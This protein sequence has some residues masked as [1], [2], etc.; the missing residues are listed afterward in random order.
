MQAATRSDSR[1][2]ITGSAYHFPGDAKSH[3]SYWALLDSG[4]SVI[5]D[6]PSERF[7]IEPYYNADANVPG[8]TYAR[9]GGYVDG[10]FDFDHSFFRISRSEALEM[11][12]QQRW[13]LELCWQALENAGIRPSEV[14]G[15]S[16]GVFLGSGEVDYG[17]RTLWSGD[18]NRITTYARLGA[19]RATL[20]GRIGY[21]LGVH[22]PA[23]FVDTACSSS[24]AAVHLAAQSLLAG[25]C[26]IAIAGGITLMI[27]PQE[28][29]AGARVQAMSHLETCRPFDAKADGYM[30]GEGGGVVVMK[31]IDDAIRDGDRIDAVMAGS[32]MNNAGPRNGL[33]APNGIAQES[34]IRVALQR[35]N[36]KPESVAYVEA[37]GTGTLLGDPIELGALHNVYSKDVHRTYPLFVGSV[38]AQIGHLEAGAGMAGL[39]KAMLVL[40]KRRIP[41]Q[42]NFLEPNPRFRWD[43]SEIR[44]PR[45][46][47]AISDEA[48]MVGVSGFGISGTNVHMVLARATVTDPVADSVADS[49]AGADGP[50]HI[51]TLSAR[52]S[53]G[54]VQLAKE[55]RNVLSEAAIGLRDI[56]YTASARRDHWNHRVALVG[57]TRERLIEALDDFLTGNPTGTWHTADAAKSRP[58]VFLFPGQGAWK[59]GVGAQ[60]YND[61]AIFHRFVDECLAYLDPTLAADVMS[62]I[63]GE[64]PETVR[65]RQGQLAH[66]VVL[67]SLARTWME[68]GHEPEVVIG[69][70]L[71]EHVAAAVA[72]VMS[73]ED[74]L[75]AVE[76]RGRLFD[77]ETPPG[78][79]LAVAAG[80]DELKSRFDFGEALFIAGINGP[81]QTVVSGTAEAVNKVFATMT[82]MG[83]RVSLLNTYDTP[84]HSPMLAPMRASFG[85]ALATLRLQPPSI[86]LISTLTGKAAG[87]D[88]AT[89]EHWLDLVENP[90]LF[91]DALSQVKDQEY[92]FLEVGPGAALS[93]LA[94]AV[95]QKWDLAISSLSD[96]PDDESTESAGFAHACARLYC[97][98]SMRNWAPL[99]PQPPQPAALPTYPFERVHLEL[100]FL[101][102]AVVP[103]GHSDAGAI[104]RPALQT[105]RGTEMDAPASVELVQAASPAR[106][107]T[108]EPA[109]LDAI[110]ELARS[111][112][113]DT[114]T[115]DDDAPLVV[116]GFDSLA[117]TEL[118]VRLQQTFGRALPVALLARGV[119]LS[120][121]AAFFGN[122][123]SGAATGSTATTQAA[124]KAEFDAV[125]RQRQNLSVAGIGAPRES[126]GTPFAE[127]SPVVVLREGHGETIVLVH[128]VGGDVLCYQDL[129]TAWPG[130]PTVI[131]V[132]HPDADLPVLPAHRPLAELARF[133]RHEVERLL[134]RLPDRLG[135]WSFGGLVAL[136]MAAQWERAGQAA[137]PLMV[138]DSPLPTGDFAL[139]L[140][141]VVGTPADAPS[142][143]DV[144]ALYRDARF[145]E[146]RDLGLDQMRARL[147]PLEFARIARLYASNVLSI[148]LR[149]FTKVGAPIH[150]ALAACGSNGR[151][152]DDV[153]PHLQ[154]LTTG[155]VNVSVF[156][157]DH[158]SIVKG[159]SA[160]RLAAFLSRSIV[161][162]RIAVNGR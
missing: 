17:L 4:R 36:A 70:S 40:Q 136:E 134:G 20:A 109:V 100:P 73:V 53:A 143:A 35:A 9:G 133:Y 126:E 159:P 75:R 93:N 63:R 11:D 52:S 91:A 38:K 142:L 128:P 7:D 14:Y 99:Y 154:R 152:R 47:E 23:V 88:M 110:R 28:T 132:R 106:K 84:G 129:A 16:V 41:A 37:H 78:A 74:S 146:E 92:V 56:C 83:K 122:A 130:D 64:R 120:G 72:G 139:R 51:L 33:T 119:S 59:P 54:R 46:S 147:A 96:G 98:G 155:T 68:L 67:Y 13:M 8:T 161:D 39:I 105:A 79:M 90:V 131:G 127:E 102:G 118:R 140:K 22:G 145:I 19:S 113:S 82:G 85:D 162:E 95:T 43:T 26:D 30:R 45:A 148:S 112:A 61:N 121:L 10:V 160:Q 3:A 137:P 12:P 34:V 71:G 156:D 81:E 50:P 58:L 57:D 21:V 27:A 103:A 114:V 49:L 125:N 69:H 94:R 86:R 44:V 104:A 80:V 32:A 2:A 153:L 150:Y 144:D 24:L 158:H 60:L 31:R 157:E 87:A 25:D 42:A 6:T 117:L 116:S 65:H 135:G 55:Y 115:L 108:G 5:R 111:V 15:R 107:D 141:A 62:A 124:Q 89:I 151:S 48:S 138:I 18:L 97:A 101:A 66:F 1:V 149:N 77:T 123:P 29:I 76:A